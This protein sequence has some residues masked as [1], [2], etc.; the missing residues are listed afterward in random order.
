MSD[1]CE[2]ACLGEVGMVALKRVPFEEAQ[3][4]EGKV[5]TAGGGR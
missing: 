1:R 2:T 4:G 3:G 5:E